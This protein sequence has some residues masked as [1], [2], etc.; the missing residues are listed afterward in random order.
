MFK[1]IRSLETLNGIVCVIKWQ[2]HVSQ[3]ASRGPSAT[4]ETLVLVRLLCAACRSGWI[5]VYNG[6]R[7]N[8][9]DC[10]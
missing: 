6:I 4:A 7:R 8:T 2:F 10:E 1:R 9:A 5:I 3:V